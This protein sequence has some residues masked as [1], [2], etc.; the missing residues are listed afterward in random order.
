M[1]ELLQHFASY[2]VW[3]N[4]RLADTTLPIDESILNRQVTG[5]FPSIRATILHLLDAE[6]I[7][8]QR[9]TRVGKFN[10]PSDHFTGNTS[11][12]LASLARQ[13]IMW[14]EW[15]ERASIDEIMEKID[16]RTTRNEQFIQPAC[17]IL[18]H[19][20]NHAT[21]H[22]GQWVNQLR[23]SGIVTIPA[24]DYIVYSRGSE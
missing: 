9:V 24:T 14:K 1:K 4:Q 17:D 3:A 20:F 7:W 11:D 16:Y 5:S 2:N 18:L 6:S 13:N 15:V 8:W 22:R 19:L 12:A 23:E 21:Y 10:R